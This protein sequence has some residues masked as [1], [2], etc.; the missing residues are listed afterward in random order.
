V[1]TERV[2]V[3]GSASSGVQICRLLAESERFREIDLAV[4]RVLVLPRRVIGVQTHRFLQVLGFF[5][6]RF[7]SPLGRI[8][9]SG[10]ET[11][12]D[13]IMRPSPK[14]L[15]RE[16]GVRLYGRLV[17]VEGSTLAF[18]DGQ[19]LETDDLTI[20]WCTGF[21]G[22][23]GLIDVE[24]RE[25]W[26]TPRG[27]PRHKRGVV[28]GMPGLYFVGL[29]YQHTVASHDIYGVAKDAAYVV[30]HIAKRNSKTT[31]SRAGDLR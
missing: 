25:E 22:D 9:Y 27:A 5:D 1:V 8:M 29:R 31:I 15:E 23:Y 13:P 2:L 11:R 19:T 16:H 7:R 4:S 18:D 17:S 12:G 26:F 3:V 24:R 6:V 10:L 28:E 30:E 14:D 20:I 21:R